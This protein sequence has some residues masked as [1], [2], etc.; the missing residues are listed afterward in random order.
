MTA[1]GRPRVRGLSQD[2]RQ[3]RAT[4]TLHLPDQARVRRTIVT[5]GLERGGTS[6]VAGIQRALGVDLGAGTEKNNEDYRFH[7]ATPEQVREVIRLRNSES[8]LWGFKYPNAGRFLPLVEQDLRN[9]YYVVVQRDP[10][11]TALS[12]S[13]WDGEETERPAWMALHEAGAIG[14]ANMAF[15]LAAEAPC[16]LVSNEL[17]VKWPGDLVDEIADFIQVDRPTG[18]F[19]ARIL[20]YLAPGSYKAFEDYFPE[21]SR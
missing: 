5:F 6:G 7:E 14:F 18:E 9:P 15:V 19:R 13:R 3:G 12:R 11:S 10:V 21:R 17:A 16:L 8:D 20:A 2:V 4:V 1:R